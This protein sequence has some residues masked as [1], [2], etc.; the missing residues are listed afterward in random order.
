MK[1]TL[2]VLVLVTSFTALAESLPKGV[3]YSRDGG[4]GEY[5][6]SFKALQE[7]QIKGRS[8]PGPKEKMDKKCVIAKD[9]KLYFA[10]DD[11]VVTQTYITGKFQAKKQFEYSEWDG[12]GDPKKVMIK[13]GEI[14]EN[15]SY[16]AEGSC[17]IRVRGKIKTNE[18]FNLAGD[19]KNLVT[20][21][22]LKSDS[23]I[24]IAC[25]GGLGW[26]S[27]EQLSKL[28]ELKSFL[29]NPYSNIEEE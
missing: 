25:E 29:Y 1:K 9:K 23:W 19:D 26:L 11:H 14:V 16:L 15:I 20:I 3:V 27:Q 12:T 28:K 13:K 24:G 18:C 10:K 17:Q 4:Q 21:S 8:L 6:A 7:I 22:E 2:A 5:P